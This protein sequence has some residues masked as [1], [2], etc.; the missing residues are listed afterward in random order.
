MILIGRE[1][2]MS[3]ECG[4]RSAERKDG[5]KIGSALFGHVPVWFSLGV[6]NHAS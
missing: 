2:H 6:F 1:V 5:E 4:K 3:A